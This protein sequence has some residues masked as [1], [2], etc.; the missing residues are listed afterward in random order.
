MPRWARK[1]GLCLRP[2]GWS[3]LQ[4]KLLLPSP[5]RQRLEQPGGPGRLTKFENVGTGIKVLAARIS[6]I[7]VTASSAMAASRPVF[8]SPSRTDTDAGVKGGDS[9][10]GQRSRPQW[11]VGCG[12][13]GCDELP[14]AAIFRPPWVGSRVRWSNSTTEYF[15]SVDLIVCVRTPAEA[16]FVVGFGITCHYRA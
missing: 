14:P 16:G 12:I 6:A 3:L 15:S 4:T 7:A 9:A 5:M 10:S 2:R 11:S 1:P 13:D 8:F